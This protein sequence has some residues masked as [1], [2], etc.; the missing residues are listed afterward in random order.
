MKCMSDLVKGV[1]ATMILFI[2]IGWIPKIGPFLAGLIGGYVAAGGILRGLLAGFLGAL[3]PAAILGAI[4][5]LA[6]GLLLGPLA[7]FVGAGASVFAALLLLGKA[8][9]A[10]IGGALGG[11]I[12]ELMHGKRIAF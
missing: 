4:V 2:A 5:A 6:G 9:V 12:A 10:S 7:V 8:L 3:A 1:M 11:L